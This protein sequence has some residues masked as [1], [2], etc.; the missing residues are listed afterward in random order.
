MY[1]VVRVEPKVNHPGGSG[2][3]VPENKLSKVT[4]EGDDDT[5]LLVGGLEVCDVTLAGGVLCHETNIM[6]V[7]AEET[8]AWGWKVLVRENFHLPVG[9]A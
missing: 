1:G 3:P 4:V 5:A 8:D 6:A 2:H 7:L 9:K